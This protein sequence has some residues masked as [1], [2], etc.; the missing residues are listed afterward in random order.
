MNEQLFYTNDVQFY[1][2]Q[3]RIAT[4]ELHSILVS[5]YLANDEK[6]SG[7]DPVCHEEKLLEIRLWNVD[8]KQIAVA[9]ELVNAPV[10]NRA[11]IEIISFDDVAL[12][13][14]IVG[15]AR[16]QKLIIWRL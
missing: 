8:S 13:T 16:G 9:V 2:L 3:K 10:V 12:I 14:D 11:M 5:Y 7:E 6:Q 1:E 4:F 15:F